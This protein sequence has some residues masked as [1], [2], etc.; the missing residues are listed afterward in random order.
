MHAI[1]RQLF[2]AVEDRNEALV[3]SLMGAVL[4]IYGET[5]QGDYVTSHG[6][7]DDL[8][9]PSLWLSTMHDNKLMTYVV[10]GNKSLIITLTRAPKGR[11][12]QLYPSGRDKEESNYIAEQVKEKGFCLA[13]ICKINGSISIFTETVVPDTRTRKLL[14][15]HKVRVMTGLLALAGVGFYVM[16]SLFSWPAIIIWLAWMMIIPSFAINIIYVLVPVQNNSARKK[17]GKRK[18]KSS[19][20]RK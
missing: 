11:W 2:Q 12:I 7:D 19:I 16:A 5:I 4:A 9:P 20:K 13:K 14:Q 6:A 15:R 1:E 17:S 8:I 18:K 3:R 10:R